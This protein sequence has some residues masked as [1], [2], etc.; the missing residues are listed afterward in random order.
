MLSQVKELNQDY[1]QEIE[2][3]ELYKKNLIKKIQGAEIG[4]G[5]AVPEDHLYEL[6]IRVRKHGLKLTEPPKG[7][8]FK[9]LASGVIYETLASVIYGKDKHHLTYRD[10]SDGINLLFIELYSDEEERET[11]FQVSNFQPSLIDKS[12][13]ELLR[14]R[15]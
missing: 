11:I 9:N 10:Y 12:T 15:A 4:E 2:N 1:Q 5:Y 14:K 13:V 7:E 3:I 8:K 6:Y